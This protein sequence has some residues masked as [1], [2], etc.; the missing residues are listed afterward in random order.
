[1][2]F[3][4]MNAGVMLLSV[5]A[6]SGWVAMQGIG[7]PAATVSAVA[8]RLG[9]AI[10]A[11]MVFNMAAVIVFS[12]LVGIA[13]GQELKDERADER[14]HAVNARAMRNAYVVA[15]ASGAVAIVL[16][17]LGVPVT[18]GIYALFGGLMLAGATDAASRL[19]FYRV[20]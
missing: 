18:L 8:A 13:Q 20:G 12:I 5:L 9:W 11:S 6:I 4:E 2:T 10:L 3:K 17:A 7:D 19:Y 15:S 1:M 16:W 14:D